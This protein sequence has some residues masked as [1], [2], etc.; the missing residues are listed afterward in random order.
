M[1]RTYICLVKFSDNGDDKSMRYGTLV[2]DEHEAREHVSRHLSDQKVEEFTILEVREGTPGET[3]SLNL[4]AG[5]VKL[6]N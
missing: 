1:H 3:A 2:A 6:L 4:S 5:Q